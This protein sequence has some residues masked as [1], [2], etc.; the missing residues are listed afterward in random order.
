[1]TYKKKNGIIGNIHGSTLICLFYG[2]GKIFILFYKIC[3]KERNDQMKKQ[4]SL[5]VAVIML[6]TTLFSAVSVNAD[7]S[8]VADDYRYK[9]AITTLSKLNIINGYDNGTFE[10]EKD[11]TRAE[12]TKIIVYMLGFGDLTEPITKFEDVSTDHWA[13]ANIKVAYDLGIINGFDDVT[14]KPDEPVTYEQALKMVVCTLGYQYMAEQNG[15]Y[16]QGY[17]SQASALGLSDGVT[18]ISFESNA[19]RGVIAQIM[20]NALEIDMYEQ[21]LNGWTATDKTLLNDYLGVYVL[22]GTVV[23]VEDSTTADCS[24]KLY[25]GQ[26]AIEDLYGT[27]YIID[28]TEYSDSYATMSAYLG[29]T[30]KAYYRQDK[31]SDDKWLVEIDNETYSNSEILVYSYDIDSYN[32]VSLKYYTDTSSRVQTV[33]L[34]SE[35]L[36]V[37]YNGRAVT[38]NVLLGDTSYSPL[39]ALKEWLNPDSDY[40]IYGTVKLMDSGSKGNYNI[41]DIYDYDTLVAYRTPSSSDYK[42]TDKTVTGNFIILDPNNVDYKFTIVKN[43]SEISTTNIATNDVI[44]YA[45]SLD[46]D[47]YTVYDT[48]KSVTGTIT[49]MSI[50]NDVENTITIDGT[51]YRVTDR[52]LQYISTKE[53]KE[54]KTGMSITAYLDVLGNLEW[55]TVSASTTFYPYAY[56]IDTVTEGEDF[57]LKLF[58]PTN[59][60]TTSFSSSTSYKVK[61]YKIADKPRLNGSSSSGENIIAALAESA[62]K[63]N[64]DVDIENVKVNL[65]GYNQLIKVGFN[66]SSEINQVITI[67]DTDGTVNTDNGY[68]VRYKAMNPESKYYV[69]SSSVK[70]SS[71]GSTFYSIR[72][73]TPMFVIPKDRTDTES[74]ALKSAV[75]SNTMISGG[76]Y[77]VEAFDLNDSKYPGCVL[78]YNSTFK[79][80]TS[81][82]KSTLYRLVADD[83]EEIYDEDEDDVFMSIPNYFSSTSLT[84]TNISSTADFGDVSIGDIILMGLDSQNY[85]DSYIKVQD[86]DE[87]LR[88][89]NGET[90]TYES[91]DG[92]TKTATYYWNETQEQ[93]ADNNWQ[94]YKFDW[95]YPKASVSEPTDNYYETGGNVTNIFSRAAMFNVIQVLADD[96]KIYVTKNGFDESGVLDESEYEEVKVSSSTKYIRYDSDKEE[97]TPYAEGTDN[98]NITLTDLKEARN[99]G[100]DCSKVLVTY[101]SS[102]S[103]S[104]TVTPT[105]RFIVIYD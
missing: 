36:T 24:A 10:P 35:D 101:T 21:S 100:A 98:T 71:S 20:Y 8:D 63:A 41:V 53:Q 47:L 49:S 18:G 92:E 38:T 60:S 6:M 4:L 29:Q 31:N 40:F 90:V 80:G 99:F 62:E 104:S 61:T 17:I 37:R 26:M 15:G 91:A 55:G 45:K 77:Y 103:S 33:N 34:N 30:V 94:L 16:P 52:F 68:L 82:T 27:E 88:I 13:N 64:P 102:T 9:D 39:D 72:S 23:G 28:Y 46:G 54:L 105:A 85:A 70:E 1:M 12:F 43:G 48:S 78:V 59:T 7:F 14:F 89:L 3:P 95:R 83:L 74:Y 56:V 22:K 87:I 11:I 51:Q 79:S 25:A 50:D 32:G 67:G 75:T 2:R 76:S 66:D 5:F 86:Y 96:S 97:F 84:T 93:T 73:T 81:I 69:T 19:P 65:T 58:A 42:I 44:N 57:Y